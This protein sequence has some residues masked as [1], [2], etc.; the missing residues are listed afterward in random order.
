MDNPRTSHKSA[1]DAADPSS[2]AVRRVMTRMVVRV[3]DATEVE[4]VLAA[5][6]DAVEIAGP[7]AARRAVVDAVGGRRTVI[8]SSPEG[9]DLVRV[10]SD[11]PAAVA[12]L[13][14]VPVLATLPAARAAEA[15]LEAAIA[16]LGA[17]GAQGVVLEA[18]RPAERLLHA[19]SVLLLRRFVIACQ[20]AGL[21]AG[22]AGGLESPDVPRLLLL[23]PDLLVFDTAVR[24]AD[25]TPDRALLRLIRGQIPPEIDD[26]ADYRLLTTARPRDDQTPGDRIFVRDFVLPVRIGAYAHER[27]APQDVRFSVEAVVSHARDPADLRDVVSYDVITDGIR[28]L[29]G[30]GHV[31]LVETLAERIAATLLAHPR[32][33]QVAVRLEKLETGSGIVGVAIERS[34]PARAASS[35]SPSEEQRLR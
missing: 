20:V 14:D 17:A 32:I 22:L 26:G 11:D 1:R 6:A 3:A 33:L 15:G 34:R 13:G 18:G 24:G 16:A 10:A 19:T 7:P 2:R 4:L 30:S 25:G 29:A 5:G 27:L 31:A 12:A 28:L 35:L 23:A 8:A 21:E 9:A